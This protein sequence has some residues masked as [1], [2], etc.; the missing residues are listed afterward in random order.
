MIAFDL[1][2]KCMLWNKA[3]AGWRDPGDKEQPEKAPLCSASCWGA[4][5]PAV[6]HD[7]ISLHSNTPPG[8]GCGQPQ[9]SADSWAEPETVVTAETARSGMA[10]TH[11]A[12]ADVTLCV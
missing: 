12:S 5:V 7:Q 2:R 6:K 10:I 8:H 9:E 3:E 4:W 11:P 1:Y